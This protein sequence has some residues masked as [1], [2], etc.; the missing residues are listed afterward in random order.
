MACTKAD[1]PVT[2]LAER[3]LPFGLIDRQ[4]DG[5]VG[6]IIRSHTVIYAGNRIGADF[7]AGHGVLIRQDNVIGDRVSVGSHGEIGFPVVIGDDVR[8][9]S[10]V[11]VSEFTVI[12]A[13][14]RRGTGATVV[15]NPAKPKD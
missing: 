15:G 3:R 12:R 8:L 7:H 10:G 13:G 1:L 2:A 11:F 5:R 6:A 4:P 9:H 14:A